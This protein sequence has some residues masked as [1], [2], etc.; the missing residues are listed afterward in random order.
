VSAA[1]APSAA[2]S[3][4][5]GEDD[6][7]VTVIWLQRPSS[8]DLTSLFPAQAAGRNISGSA[9][10]DCAVLATGR[11]S[12]GIAS[13]TPSGYGFGRAAMAVAKKFQASAKAQDGRDALGKRTRVPI[14]FQLAPVTNR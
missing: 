7:Y 4:T 3:Q 14:R 1:P 12:C 6:D 8:S 10:L 9:L 2:P 5:P 13:E 11:L